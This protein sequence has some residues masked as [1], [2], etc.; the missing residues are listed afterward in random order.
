MASLGRLLL[1]LCRIEVFF[2]ADDDDVAPETEQGSVDPL[3]VELQPATRFQKEL[4]GRGE[5]AVNMSL[6][7]H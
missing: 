5:G 4:P 6:I 7:C 3:S 1:M 2:T